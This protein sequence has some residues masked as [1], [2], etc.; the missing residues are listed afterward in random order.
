MQF[1]NMIKLLRFEDATKLQQ[2]DFLVGLA[3]LEKRAMFTFVSKLYQAEERRHREPDIKN[4]DRLVRD[5]VLKS[6]VEVAIK[7]ADLKV[8]H[9]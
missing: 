1:E 6:A 4:E 5:T 7:D 2:G 9:A 3:R 8:E